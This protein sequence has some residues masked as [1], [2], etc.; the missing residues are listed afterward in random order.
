M[1]LTRRHALTGAAALAATPLLPSTPSRAAAQVADKQAPSYYRYEIGDIQVTVVSDGRNTF[2]LEDSFITNA[3]KEEVSAALEKAFLPRDVMTIYFAP[4]V[5]NTGG[6]LI[7]LDTGNGPVAKVNSKGANGMFAANMA[8]AG[9]D[10]KA[11]DMVV[12]SHFHT[13]T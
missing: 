10:P 8:A 6:K 12:I 1:Q 5:I 2:P 13:T 9:F 4:L 3:K 11:V 7:V